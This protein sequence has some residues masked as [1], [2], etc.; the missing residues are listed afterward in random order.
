[1]KADSLVAMKYWFGVLVLRAYPQYG[2]AQG[3]NEL[4][5]GESIVLEPKQTPLFVR[6]SMRYYNGEGLVSQRM[7]DGVLGS[8]RAVAEGEK[9]QP[10]ESGVCHLVIGKHYLVGGEFPALRFYTA[11]DKSKRCW[12]TNDCN[13]S[14]QL[15]ILPHKSGDIY[16]DILLTD[17]QPQKMAAWCFNT[18]NQAAR[19]TTCSA[20]WAGR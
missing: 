19:R 16:H 11:N 8:L 10:P 5:P 4:K 14:R 3:I 13:S 17:N 6:N 9:M 7:S 1:M 20:A 18:A 2:A 12:Q 15:V